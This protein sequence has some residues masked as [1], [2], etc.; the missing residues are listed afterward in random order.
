MTKKLY[1]ISTIILVLISLIIVFEI[2]RGS[3]TGG[4][5]VGYINAGN[6]VING[7]DIYA[8]YLNTWP[9]LF[10]V[11]SVLLGYIDSFSSFF[12]R[13]V[14]LTGSVIAM[15]CIVNES[16]KLVLNKPISL[17]KTN[18]TIL[19]Q[20][21]VVLIPLLIILRFF[22][23]NLANVQINIYMLLCSLLTIIFFIKKNICGLEFC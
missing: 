7:Q 8:D 17:K 4:D 13:F 9:P 1:S 6:A 11:F 21:T 2:I 15:Y 5:F 18:K 22:I 3:L 10:S 12:I 20:N 19:I 16:A 14:W 23:D